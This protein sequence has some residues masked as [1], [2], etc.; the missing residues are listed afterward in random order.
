MTYYPH[1]ENEIK[2]MLSLLG[3]SSLDEL[4]NSIPSKFHFD[5]S[6]KTIENGKTEL[7]V[8]KYFKDISKKNKEYKSIFLGAGAY[9][10]YIPAVIDEIVTRQEFY[11]A[12]TPY[13]SEVSQGTLRALFE[14]QTYM[15]E[16][17][18]LDVSNASLY[19][20]ATALAEAVM[21]AIKIT[22]KTK[23]L[24]D[25][26][27]HP[28]YLEV[29]NTY[30]NQLNVKIDFFQ[31]DPF[32]FNKELFKN[33]WNNEYACF[34][35]QSPNFCGSIYDLNELAD[36]IHSTNGLFIQCITEPLS[37]A[38]LKPPG[39]YGVDIACGEAQSFGIPLSFG[40]PYLGFITCKKD[41][42]R[43]LPGR[44]VGQTLDANSKISY[45]LTLS[46]REQHI[47]REGATSNICS[48]HGLCAIRA[49]IYLSLL[50]KAGIKSCA[51]KNIENARLIY[52]KI[53][54]LRKF[55]VIDNQLFFNE[56]VVKTD[57]N[58]NI[59]KRALEENDILSF[60]SLGTI[61][62]QL[63]NHYLICATE[64]NDKNEIEKFINVLENLQ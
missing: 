17:T 1:S 58:E 23:V 25:R 41:F 46:T 53:K 12:Y 61:Y 4:K 62:S 30:L 48:N 8:Y 47:R 40:G 56:F 10:H 7:E 21:M 52:D 6:F 43:K 14:Y 64:M 45:T 31:N 57:I 5:G 16:L 3:L 42:L 19:D 36:I 50:G 22:G 28:E 11:T 44:I 60:Y 32:Y 55:N 54:S 13:Q 20:G 15:A 59:I 34:A 27:I 29:L 49:S 38:I 39:E 35:V 26:F 63:K 37:L 51:L 2:E 24:I 33:C 18:K 9:N